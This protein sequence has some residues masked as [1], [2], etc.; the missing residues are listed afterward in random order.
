MIT[1]PNMQDLEEEELRS[2]I[3]DCEM[4][5]DICESFV[6]RGQEELARRRRIKLK[7]KREG[8]PAVVPEV[9]PK[10]H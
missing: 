4:Q 9:R 3:N 1:I 7:E 8:L 6:C 10:M 2:M 5:R